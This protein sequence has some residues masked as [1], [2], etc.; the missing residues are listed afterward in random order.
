MRPNS[1]ER[2]G[3]ASS[4]HFAIVWQLKSFFY[5]Y[6]KNIIGGTLRE[7]NNRYSEDGKLTSAAI[8]LML[9]ATAL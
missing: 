6:G 5:A 1:A 2:P 9:G 8:P 7:A 4:P 3:W